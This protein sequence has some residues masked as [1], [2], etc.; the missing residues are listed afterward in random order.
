M[1]KKKLYARDTPKIYKKKKK[2][3]YVGLFTCSLRLLCLIAYCDILKESDCYTTVEPTISGRVLQ[4]Y[5]ISNFF[6]IECDYQC[7]MLFY[8]WSLF[9]STSIFPGVV[10]LFYEASGFDFICSHVINVLLYQD[11]SLKIYSIG[12][13]VR[14][15]NDHFLKR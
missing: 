1:I 10:C 6:F 7:Q 3:L 2:S 4:V 13:D 14:L 8:F 15:Q 9:R 12:K 5:Q 11:S